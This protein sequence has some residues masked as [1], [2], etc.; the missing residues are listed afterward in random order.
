[1]EEHASEIVSFGSSL[2]SNGVVVSVIQKD[3]VLCVNLR[4]NGYDL[5]LRKDEAQWFY[6]K[7]NSCYCGVLDCRHRL[8]G[9]FDNVRIYHKKSDRSSTHYLRNKT[10]LIKLRLV[11][12]VK[13][14]LRKYLLYAIELFTPIDMKDPDILPLIIATILK[15]KKLTCPSKLGAFREYYKSDSY[16]N[17]ACATT[18]HIYTEL[19]MILIPGSYFNPDPWTLHERVYKMLHRDDFKQKSLPSQYLIELIIMKTLK[20]ERKCNCC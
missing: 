7:L 16:F 1:M 15:K 3:S 10:C 13:K 11:V 8:A 4:S 14:A 9:Q 20:K 5:Q 2:R 6:D 17:G 12:N 19:C 18:H